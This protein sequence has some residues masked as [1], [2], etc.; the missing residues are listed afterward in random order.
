MSDPIRDLENFSTG[1][2]PMTPLP[3]AEVRRRGDRL[4]R[5]NT[6]LLSVA[7]AVAVAAIVAAPLALAGGNDKAG[8]DTG[9]ATRSPS[10]TSS[11]EDGGAWLASI[12]ADFPLEEGYP[13]DNEDGTPVTVAQVDAP[14]SSP[15][16]TSTSA[17]AT[18]CST[19]P[20]CPSAPRG[21]PQPVARGLP[22][23]RHRR[24]R[25]GRDPLA[26]HGLPHGGG[27][28]HGDGAHAV[29]PDLGER[30]SGGRP[31]TAPTVSSTSGWGSSTPCGSGTPSC[32]T[33]PTA[34]AAR[35]LTPGRPRW[36]LPPRPGGRPSEPYGPTLRQGRRPTTASRPTSRSTRPQP[37]RVSLDGLGPAE[38]PGTW[39]CTRAAR[40]PPGALATVPESRCEVVR[41][42]VPPR[43]HRPGARG[44]PATEQ[45]ATSRSPG[46][47]ATAPLR[48]LR[49]PSRASTSS[50]PGRQRATPRH[51]VRHGTPGP[52][53]PWQGRPGG[54]HGRGSRW[55]R[56]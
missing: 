10:A 43:R 55:S 56:R 30:S 47:S 38:A 42:G 29:L 25:P 15:C 51:D 26:G 49:R 18:T 54:R 52:A 12:P 17:S 20:R 34:R 41:Y 6:T 39:C 50:G 22:R 36:T 5:R 11:T 31:A 32:S 16:A 24:P 14:S 4:R 40:R 37:P 35:R 27:E 19:V 48:R 1:G 3:A 45:P 23:R 9:F 7:G 13:A 44:V 21:R 46:P 33:R 28:G 8:P 53:T 2:T